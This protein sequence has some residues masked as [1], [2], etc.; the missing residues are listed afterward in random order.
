MT[1]KPQEDYFVNLTSRARELRPESETKILHYFATDGQGFQCYNAQ[2][3]LLAQPHLILRDNNG[4]TVLHGG[5]YEHVVTNSQGLFQGNAKVP[6]YDFRLA[7]ARDLYI[8]GVV[9]IIRFIFYKCCPAILAP[10]IQTNG[11]ADGVFID[12]TGRRTISNCHYS[13]C[14]PAQDQCC[15][16]SDQDDQEYNQGLIQATP[17]SREYCLEIYTRLCSA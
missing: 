15:Q 5:K 16:F 11:G 8:K 10:V 3:E 12:G 1:S 6:F 4:D 9:K 17:E 14:G 2:D 13:S 7:E